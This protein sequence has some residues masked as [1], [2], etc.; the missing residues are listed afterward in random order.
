MS[1]WFWVRHGPTHETAFAGWRDIPADLS[2]QALIRRLEACLPQD[3][4]V[5][6]S[7][8]LRARQTADA[9]LGGRRLLDPDPDLREFNF[10]DW[11]GLT[12]DMVAE[13][14]PTLSRAYWEQPGDVAPPNGESWNAASARVERGV[15]RLQHRHP[16]RDIIVVA[17]FGTILTRVQR[18]TSQSAYQTLAQR[19]DNLSLTE[20][21]WDGAHWSLHQVNTL[22]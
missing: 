2:D 9:I 8:L 16:D 7:D 17:H 12:F 6:S 18:A 5:I 3:A 22:P 1:R 11:D 10:G 15:A 4:L 20:V 13:R 21:H 14:D 19:I